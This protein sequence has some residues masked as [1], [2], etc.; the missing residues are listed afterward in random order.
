MLCF[1]KNI[2]HTAVLWHDLMQIRNLYTWLYMYMHKGCCSHTPCMYNDHLKDLND[3]ITFWLLNT[4]KN[5]RVEK[6]TQTLSLNMVS[7]H[8]A[9]SITLDFQ[10]LPHN[11]REEGLSCFW[12]MHLLLPRLT[13]ASLPISFVLFIHVFSVSMQLFVKHRTWA[14]TFWGI[15]K[16][17]RWP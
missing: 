1:Y 3:M 7:L 2:S 10:I 5:I 12:R 6:K 14:A 4:A 13:S 9:P 16:P 11:K 17:D 15:R 8:V